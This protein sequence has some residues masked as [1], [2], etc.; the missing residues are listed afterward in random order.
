MEG[1]QTYFQANWQ[2]RANLQ[3][4][5]RNTF[6]AADVLL[7]AMSPLAAR[8]Q[9]A[10]IYGSVQS[11]EEALG[12]EVNP[13]VYRTEEFCR[14]LAEGRHFV[15]QVVSGPK[16]FLIGDERELRTMASVWVAKAAGV[17]RP[18]GSRRS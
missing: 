8:V 6:G 10:F 3:G 2:R 9:L 14:K 15:S 4:L 1:R 12:R 17:A 5:V 11:P 13:S 16:I 18:A 7:A